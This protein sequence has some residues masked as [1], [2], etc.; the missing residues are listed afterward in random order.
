MNYLSKIN[1]IITFPID[2]LDLSEYCIGY[3]KYYS[4][5]SLKSVILHSGSLNGGH[6]YAYCKHID[7][8]WYEYND[9]SCTKIDIEASKNT[10]F[11][12]GYILVYEKK[13]EE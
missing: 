9:S 11:R 4:K 3:E 7:G 5:L 10:L 1:N 6:Y 12:N 2:D 8:Q 13:D